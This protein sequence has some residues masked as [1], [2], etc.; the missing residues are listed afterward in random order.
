MSANGDILAALYPAARPRGSSDL[1]ASISR[2][3]ADHLAVAETFF[4]AEAENVQRAARLLADCFAGGGR[5]LTM[6]N[7]GSSTDAAHLAIEF[8]HPITTG[9]PALPAINL[10][11]DVALVTAVGNDAGFENIFVR[12]LIAHGRKG[13]VL[14]GFSTSGNSK[15]LLRA[16]EK[17]KTMGIV[18]LGFAGGDG[19]AM[20]APGA[21]DLCLTVKTPSVHRVQEVHLLTYHI[22]WDLT[23]T[24]L[25]EAAAP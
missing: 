10:T 11:A 5:L 12:P 23:C 13:D 22:L 1:A 7:G 9:R 8:Q 4:A 6:G 16:F 20:A 3:L 19:G 2:K 18:T 17:A 14:A 21:L 24:L 15:N 25:A